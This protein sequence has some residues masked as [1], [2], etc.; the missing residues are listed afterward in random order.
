MTS[1]QESRW[2]LKS[3]FF[4]WMINVTVPTGIITLFLDVR[5]YGTV[6]KQWVTA[7]KNRTFLVM[8]S[9]TIS[10]EGGDSGWGGAGWTTVEYSQH[11]HCVPRSPAENGRLQPGAAAARG[12]LTSQQ[13]DS[14]LESWLQGKGWTVHSLPPLPIFILTGSC[15]W[16][17][18]T[19]SRANHGL[20]LSSQLVLVVM[21]GVNDGVFGEVSRQWHRARLTHESSTTGS[22]SKAAKTTMA[23]MKDPNLTDV[24]RQMHPQ[25][26]DSSFYSCPHNSHT[27]IDFFPFSA[28]ITHRTL[29]SKYFSRI[30]S[31]HSL[32]TLSVLM[33]ATFWGTR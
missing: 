26:R 28:Q 13:R 9:P 4:L 30:L 7:L 8:E 20:G 27:R 16:L 5:D 3:S 17:L 31:D 12:R 11:P 32:L 1:S 15:P 21:T 6:A 22:K 19:R 14:L 18:M 29:E 10:V 23:F 33:A 2:T 24:W 25:P